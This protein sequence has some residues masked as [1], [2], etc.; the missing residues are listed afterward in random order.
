MTK[1]QIMKCTCKHKYQDS[2]YS[3]GKRVHNYGLKA[4]QGYPGWRCTVCSD[5][6]KAGVKE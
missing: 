3:S 2:Q 1:T 6:K 5:T 4:H